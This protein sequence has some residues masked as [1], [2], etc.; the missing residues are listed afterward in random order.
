MRLPG[1]ERNLHLYE[2][3][4]FLNILATTTFLS[5]QLLISIVACMGMTPGLISGENI[6][7]EVAQSFNFPVI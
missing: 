7:I 4:V 3:I 5:A 2:A 1:E 6:K